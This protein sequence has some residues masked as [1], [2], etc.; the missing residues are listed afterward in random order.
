M[1]PGPLTN[2]LRETLGVFEGSTAPLTTSEVADQLAIGRRSTYD[3]LERLVDHGRLETKSVG[4]SA[5]VWWRPSAGTASETRTATVVDDTERSQRVDIHGDLEH[6]LTEIFDRID[7]GFCAFDTEFRCTY[8]NDRVLTLLGLTRSELIG[9]HIWTA[10]GIAADDSIRALFE[11]AMSTQEPMRVE[12][13]SDRLEI[14][15]YVR[16]YPSES[17]LSVY[18][19]DITDRKEHERELA[20]RREQLVELNNINGVIRQI[21]DA[22]ITQSIREEI[23]GIVCDCLAAADS[24]EFAWI[25]DVDAHS[26]TLTPRAEAGVEG[27]LEEVTIS[28]DPDDSR[29]QG[30]GGKAIQ[31]GKMQVIQDAMANPKFETWHETADRYGYR[32]VAAIPISYGGTLYGLLAVYAARP[33][34]FDGEVGD[35]IAQL[36][37]IV[38]HAIAATERKQALMGHD[39]TEIQFVVRDLLAQNGIES[40]GSGTITFDKAV[41]IGDETFLQYGTVDT[42]TLG[43]LS[44]LAEALPQFEAMTVVDQDDT[45]AQFE[46]RASAPPIVSI[47]A[48]H[49]GHVQ[50]SK[51]VDGD[52]HITI[53]LPP[54]VAARRV[55]DAIRETY[56][57]TSLLTRRQVTR[58]EESLAGVDRTITEALT[59][60]QRSALETAVYSGYFEW[61]RTASGGDLAASLGVSSPTFHQHLRKAQ[62]HVFESVLLSTSRL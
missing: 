21:T 43:T 27:Y 58:H 48:S 53:Q 56:P 35:V 46:L 28:V 36:G 52:L 42:D 1:A 61:P 50:E 12:R 20:H 39:L 55:V 41:P 23:E 6:E 44:A 31:T 59:D 54:T 24:Y 8:A 3:R 22:V 57:T 40:D 47:V 17:G 2:A 62:K 4:A 45:T 13:Y 5:R 37:E 25:A 7:D 26:Q 30:P 38:G 32:S 33:K 11:T 51:I 18:V 9:H 16:L 10:A 15:E 29:G 49:G 14:W 34:A 60:R 19:T